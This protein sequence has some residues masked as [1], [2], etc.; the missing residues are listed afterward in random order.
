[1]DNPHRRKPKIIIEIALSGEAKQ[2]ENRRWG[3]SCQTD[4]YFLQPDFL[5]I[6]RLGK[7]Q[8]ESPV[9]EFDAKGQ[10][11]KQRNYEKAAERKN[12][13]QLVDGA[14]GINGAGNGD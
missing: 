7:Q 2:I 14:P 13:I 3:R 8:S 12:P 9:L 4:H 6:H 5:S 1:S 11:G 10:R